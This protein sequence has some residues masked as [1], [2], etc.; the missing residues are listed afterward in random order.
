MIHYILR[1][2]YIYITYDKYYNQLLCKKKK[3]AFNHT[4]DLRGSKLL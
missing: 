3:K 2:I 4:K 1:D